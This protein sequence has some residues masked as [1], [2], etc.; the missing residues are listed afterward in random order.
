MSAIHSVFA[1]REARMALAIW[2]I[3]PTIF[4]FFTIT[5]A[6]DPS[7]QLSKVRVGVAILDKGVQTPN[8]NMVVGSQLVQGLHKQAPFQLIQF[9]TE[10]ELRNALLSRQIA[11]GLIFPAD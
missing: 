7:T 3:I 10:N 11:G 4:L 8:G 5:L 2:A 6:V 9:P 1:Q